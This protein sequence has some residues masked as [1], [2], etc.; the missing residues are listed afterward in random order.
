MIY[1]I[2]GAVGV[3]PGPLTIREL[4]QMSEGRSRSLWGH[5][6]AIVATI[7]NVNRPKGKAPIRPDVVNPWESRSAGQQRIPINRNNIALLKA[8]VGQETGRPAGPEKG[9]G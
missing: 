1:Q 2:A 7:L 9:D 8:L 6:S 3:D 4:L 5:T